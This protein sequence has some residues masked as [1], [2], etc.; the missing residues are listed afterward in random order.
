MA[1]TLLPPICK[2]KC[3]FF[4]YVSEY[5]M[6]HMWDSFPLYIYPFYP[7]ASDFGETLHYA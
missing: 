3:Y 5:R 4:A 6:K 2:I 1:S 7:S